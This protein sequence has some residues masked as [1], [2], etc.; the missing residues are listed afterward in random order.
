MRFRRVTLLAVLYL[1]LDFA[2]PMLPGAVQFLDGSLETDA[3]CYARSAKNPA[4]AVAPLP[5]RLSTVVSA[6]K[7]TRATGRIISASPPAPVI[8]RAP[9]ESRSTPASSPDDD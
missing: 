2:N 8:F 4:P 6:R 5:R 9:V 3:G 7:P 1:A